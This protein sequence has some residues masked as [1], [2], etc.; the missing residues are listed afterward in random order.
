MNTSTAMS[1]QMSAADW[2]RLILLSILWGGSFFFVELAVRELPVFTVVVARVALAAVILQGILRAM[3]QRLPRGW[4]IWG[5]FLGM[6]LLNNVIPFS[7]FF[8][9]QTQIAS[10]LAAI[11]NATTP[12]F[13]V[14][15][16]HFLTTDERL[17]LA[18]GSGVLV[19][20]LGVAMMLGGGWSGGALL[21]QLACLAAALSYGFAGVFGRRFRRMK[22]TAMQSATGQVTASSLV[23]IPLMCLVDQPW[24]LPMPS[25][26]TLAALVGL[27]ALSTAL[28]YVL[29]FR[30][31]ETAGASNVLLVTFLVPVSALILGV[32]IL[33]E[34]LE[35]HHLMGMALI[36]L[37]LAAIDGRL[38]RRFALRRA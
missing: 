27:A 34:V 37:G 29:Y 22:V 19:G 16:A 5:A 18:K 7:L 36:G 17:T 30:I 26:L 35:V 25:A 8:W 2:L 4:A 1:P 14:L 11:L 38:L 31:L 10:G 21:A 33:G 6:G 9:G 23:M 28:A 3:G 13:G 32:G 24:A 20:F 12:L 15:V